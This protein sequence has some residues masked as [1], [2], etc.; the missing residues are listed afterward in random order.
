[1]K[2]RLALVLSALLLA[3]ACSDSKPT[4]A[5]ASN[6]TVDTSSDESAV[7]P[8]TSGG[9]TT[10]VTDTEIRI[11]GIFQ[12]SFFADAQGGAQARI[13]RL[14]AAGG[15]HGRKLVLVDMVDDGADV[16][17]SQAAAKRLVEQEKVFAIGPIASAAFQAGDYLKEQGVP[18]FGWGISPTWCGNE[19]GFSL[20][21][22]IDSSR[23][24]TITDMTPVYAKLLG[25]D[26]MK[27]KSAAIV[28]DDNDT[29]RAQIQPMAYSYDKAGVTVAYQKAVLPA[30]PAVVGD[31]TPYATDIMT[32]NNGGPPDVV[33]LLASATNAIGLG[34]KLR[35]LGFTGAILN[36]ILYAPAAV[37][38]AKLFTTSVSSNV[39]EATDSPGITQ[40][41]EDLDAND[42]PHSLAA[43]TAYWATEHLIQV[44]DKVGPA[45]SREAFVKVLNDGFTFD[46]KGVFTDLTYP[47]AHD[48][49]IPPCATMV[50]SDGTQFTVA[51]PFTCGKSVPNPFKK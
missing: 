19:V 41:I 21:R 1:M 16:A 18:F 32:S 49:G 40:T 27:G 47:D 26:S 17:A 45:L 8:S 9:D 28:G 42:T 38:V 30:P 11:G 48:E 34:S 24:T 33:N 25:V 36:G 12:K 23:S 10:G 50:S 43:L 5:S 22:C 35:E 20:V 4:T 14:N 44:L 31:F 51:V 37:S 29:G 7:T 46:G 13:D 3:G 39:F 2:R 6:E 15:V